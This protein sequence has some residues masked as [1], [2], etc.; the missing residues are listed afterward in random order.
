M[1]FEVE[2]DFYTFLQILS[3]AGF[4]VLLDIDLFMI[5]MLRNRFYFIITF[6]LWSSKL[7]VIQETNQSI[8]NCHIQNFR[9][10]RN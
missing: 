5:R 4:S 3:E 7:R 10:L 6:L 2:I 9:C 1:T 8:V